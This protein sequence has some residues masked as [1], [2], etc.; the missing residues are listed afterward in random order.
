MA[1][2]SFA[3]EGADMPAIIEYHDGVDMLANCDVEALV[4]PVNC[5]GV[6]GKGLALQVKMAY[7]NN[8]R[9]YASTCARGELRPGRLFTYIRTAPDGYVLDNPTFIVNFP[10]KRHWRDPSRLADIKLGL[11]A[12]ADVIA[13]CR[14]RS[15]AIPQ[16]GCG[17]GGLNWAEVR[18]LILTA[19]GPI[20]NLRLK[21][22][23]PG[24]DQI[25]A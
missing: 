8:F 16:L 2:E 9:A 24:P 22:Y 12:L 18:P 5:V 3:M 11:A 20:D 21:I 4:N 17:L 13:Q 1:V 25:L 6:M 14:I 10:T 19:L 7:P 15:I 23:E